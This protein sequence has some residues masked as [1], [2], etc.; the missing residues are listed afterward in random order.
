M[1]RE[2]M[3]RGFCLLELDETNRND[4]TEGTLVTLLKNGLTVLDLPKSAPG[5]YIHYGA[6]IKLLS[7][8]DYVQ[9]GRA[10]ITPEL[11]EK[12]EATLK[13]G[14]KL[15]LGHDDLSTL[16]YSPVGVCEGVE[17][18]AEKSLDSPEGV[19]ITLH[20]YNGGPATELTFNVLLLMSLCNLIRSCCS[21]SLKSKAVT[22]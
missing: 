16:N 6:L 15:Y 14:S 21:E 9:V 5:V 22:S 20:I 3:V 1:G 19:E 2:Y 17:Y 4:F 13:G 11:L 10:N 7:I 12:Q 8:V 18:F